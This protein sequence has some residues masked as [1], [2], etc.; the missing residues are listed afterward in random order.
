MANDIKARILVADDQADLGEALRFLF[1][2]EG[3]R[4]ELAQSP[5]SALDLVARTE[6]D[7]VFADLNYTRDT[8]GG[9]EGL[10]LLARLQQ[11][12]PQLPVVVM[13]AWASVDVAVEA[14]R[15]G[16]RD[17]V[18]KPWDNARVL[19]I[20]RN[21]IALRRA[22]RQGDRLAAAERARRG[23]GPSLVAGSA[24]M[25]PV[26]ELIQRVGPSDATVLITG[27]NGTGKGVV[28]EAIHAAS[29]RFGGPFVS[30]NMGGLS[31]TLFESELFGHVKGAFTDA[32]ADRVG[33]FEMA[34]GGTLFL[35]EIANMPLPQQAKLL[36][37]LETRSFE[38]LGSSRTQLADVRLVAAT[39]ADL[40]AEVAAGRFRQDLLFRLNTIE[41]RLPSLRER[42]DDVEP[43]ARHS[44]ERL[45]LRYRK[46]IAGFEPAAVAVMKSHS[47]PGNVRELFHAVERGVLMA[48][49][50]RIRAADLGLFTVREAAKPLEE[51]SI[52]EVER[53]LIRQT[54]ARC[55]GN[56][57][58]AAEQLGLSRS[59]F[60]R[61]LEKYG[62]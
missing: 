44:L 56:A 34:E 58:R 4:T 26:M 59:A 49:G 14:M 42:L 20:A 22:L 48:D 35:D 61:R 18:Q 47:W 7:L 2:A 16:A 41:I 51:M 57:M 60:Y 10:E 23:G 33:R 17:F 31:E 6:F 62:L 38:R 24:A 5:E 46:D 43:L 15:R 27:E 19:A 55:D 12:D 36:R 45:R 13:T 28:A 53:F 29:P 30:V 21:Q 1:K 8:T 52:E 11:L 3:W 40:R 32:R 39:N 37:V 25:R 50:P 9:T 54:L